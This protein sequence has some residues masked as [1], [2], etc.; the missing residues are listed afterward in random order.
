MKPEEVAARI[1]HTLLKPDATTEQIRR[2]CAEAKEHHFAAVC[3]NPVQVSLAAELLC[4]S[5]VRVCTVIGFP[6][7]ATSTLVKVLEARDAMAAGAQELDMVINVGALKEGKTDLVREDIRA[8]VEAGHPR[9]AV[10]VILE[11]GFLT[12]GEIGQACRL[13][14]EAGADYVKTSTGF[15]PRG[16]SVED[17]R[18]MRRE[19]APNVKIK[20][21]GGIRNWDTAVAMIEA[22]ADRIG[23][24]AGVQIVA[25]GSA[26]K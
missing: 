25:E 21:A 7:G 5:Q 2:L 15:G 1:D 13:A 23:A 11:T 4:G 16:A 24:S 14:S 22:G 3:V 10:K 9:A 17:V 26:K 6:L 20:A 12:G 8:V 18:I 19:A